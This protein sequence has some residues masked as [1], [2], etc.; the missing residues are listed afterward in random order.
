V[1]DLGRSYY[2][3]GRDGKL[4]GPADLA[5]LAGW[6]QT[7]RLKPDS[8]LQ[9][10]DTGQTYRADTIPELQLALSTPSPHSGPGCLPA[11]ISLAAAVCFVLSRA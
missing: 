3:L 10:P 2:V 6:A 7:R 8:V 4:Y 11:I 1:P 9:D 5:T